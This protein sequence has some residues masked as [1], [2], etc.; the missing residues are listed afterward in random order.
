[1]TEYRVIGTSVPRVDGR[2]KVTGAMKYTSDMTVPGLLHAKVLRSPHPH[3]R[4]LSI[5]VA[6]AAQLPGVRAI[7]TGEDAPEEKIGE[8]I[9]DRYAL[10]R[11]I[12]RF[13]GEPVAAVAADTAEIAAEAI[14]LIQVDYQ[15]LAAVFDVEEA[16]AAEPAVVVHPDISSYFILQLPNQTI[17]LPDNM[18]NAYV[19]RPLNCGDVAKGFAEADVVTEH[20]FTVPRTQFGA[21]ERRTVIAQPES[22]ER[23]TFWATTSRPISDKD[24]VA[25]IL[26]LSPAKVTLLAPPL[27]GHFGA[28]NQSQVHM[29]IA[30]LLA[31][32]AAAPVRLS[33]TREE[34]VTDFGTREGTVVY[35]KQGAS[36]DGTLIAREIKVFVETG[37]Y[38][39]GNLALHC[40][41]MM[42]QLIGVYRVPNCKIDIYGV[43]TNNPPAGSFLTFGSTQSHWAMEQSMDVLAEQLGLDRREIR[44]RNILEEGQKNPGGAVAQSVGVGMCL[45]KASEWIDWAEPAEQ[46]G[47]PWRTGKGLALGCKHTASDA[48]PTIVS[49]KIHSD[50]TIEVRHSAAEQGMGILTTLA[51]LAAEEFNTTMDKIK[52]VTVDAQSGGYCLGT[53]GQKAT[54]NNGNALL[55]ASRDVKRQMFEAAAATLNV[56]ADD[57]TIEDGLIFSKVNPDASITI[58][59]L[60]N[61][62]GFYGS[63]ELLGRAVYSLAEKHDV[64]ENLALGIA[65]YSSLYGYYAAAAEVA[66][67]VETGEVKILRLGI[68][69][70]MGTPINPRMIDVH[71]YRGLFWGVG[72]AFLEEVRI[73]NGKI[74]NP[75]FYRWTM[76]TA[77]DMPPNGAVASLIASAPYGDGPLG[78]KGFAEGTMVPVAPALN[79]AIAA[80]VGI[81]VGDAPVTKDKILAALATMDGSAVAQA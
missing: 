20:R 9:K 73:E 2:D 80:A 40:V 24:D 42:S 1:M 36:K 74:V 13:I 76:P 66:V 49:I 22:D 25:R 18:P 67:N 32:K 78:A 8:Y 41:I 48:G 46:L 51:Q 12:V 16:A 31:R 44:R 77:M 81:R 43:A 28:N 75:D 27:G 35:I 5:D 54:T 7:I 3:A 64:K 57:L 53:M 38:S 10:A 30:A 79:N 15:P 55:L 63:G 39:S 21:M 4:I 34:D 58:S 33:L 65:N 61:V 29:L 56:Q 11:D 62:F 68:C 17:R 26:G 19:H 60:F 52:L 37:A 14:K 47:G 70:D 69:S 59:G 72:T 50:A 23:M 45:E 71:N 6:L